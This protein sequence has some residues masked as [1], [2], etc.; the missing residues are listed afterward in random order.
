MV[1]LIRNCPPQKATIHRGI[2]SRHGLR[3]TSIK[4]R[5]R[6]TRGVILQDRGL[7][8][9]RVGKMRLGNRGHRPRRTATPP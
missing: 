5:L 4:V 6:A 7:E 8:V 1:H 9:R 3:R 2:E